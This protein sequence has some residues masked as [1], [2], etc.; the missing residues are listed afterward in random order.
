MSGE[1]SVECS[2]AQSQRKTFELYN[3][4]RIRSITATYD[5]IVV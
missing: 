5:V 1:N 2:Y 3:E 4:I